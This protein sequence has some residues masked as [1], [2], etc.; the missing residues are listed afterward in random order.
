MTKS[1]AVIIVTWNQREMVLDCLASLD[2]LNYPSDMLEVVVVDNGS[3]D[4]TAAAIHDRFPQVVVKENHKNLGFAEGNNVGIRHALGLHPD[5]ICLLNNDTVVTPDFIVRLVEE[6]E[7]EK[8][9]GMA[10]PKMYFFDPP[11]MVFA[12]G[13]LV[14]WKEGKLNQRGI[15]QREGI[16][17]PLFSDGPEDVD[18]IIG[19]G[20]LIKREVL[21]QI[22][23]FDSRYF[24]NF[25]D[26]DLCIRA[27]R[28]GYRVRYTPRAVL[29]HKVS[30]SLGQGSPRNVYY[31]TRNALLFF[32]TYLQG[33][34]RWLTLAR[35]VWR[36]VGHIATWTVNPQY[37]R[38]ARNKR[39]ANLLALRDA[40]LGR[41]G[42]MGPDVEA[43]CRRKQ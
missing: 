34:Q 9:V 6:T 26:V 23:L 35:I 32:S 18:F 2:E 36:S 3:S 20:V 39:D 42:E 43:V 21:E 24:L 25:E 19:C 37:R 22:G 33:W 31:M 16:V 12:A 27:H 11:D 15:R 8:S 13:S 28:A 5:Y 10:G 38:S 41:F 30:A 4:G 29:F 7:G 1:V 17:G 14:D 40:V